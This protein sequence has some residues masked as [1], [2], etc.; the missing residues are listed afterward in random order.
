MSTLEEVAILWIWRGWTAAGSEVVI[1]YNVI[2]D[3]NSEISANDRKGGYQDADNWL[4]DV[5]A[6]DRRQFWGK[7]MLLVMEP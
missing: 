6:M 7:A 1:T 4:T 2:P 5:K 3:F